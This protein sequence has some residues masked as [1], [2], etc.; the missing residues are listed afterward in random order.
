MRK[1]VVKNVINT[2]SKLIIKLDEAIQR[3][4]GKEME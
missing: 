2:Y 4:V 1:E 3:Q